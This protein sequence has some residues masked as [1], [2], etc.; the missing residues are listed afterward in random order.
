MEINVLNFNNTGGRGVTKNT[1]VKKRRTRVK[2]S[3]HAE[4]E[5]AELDHMVRDLQ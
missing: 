4:K 2:K 3:E 5:N 1:T